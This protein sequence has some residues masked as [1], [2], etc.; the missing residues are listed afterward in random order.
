MSR[1]LWLKQLSESEDFFHEMPHGKSWK[2]GNEG[3]K[4]VFR[5]FWGNSGFS[6][7]ISGQKEWN[8]I[9]KWLK[10]AKIRERY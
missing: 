8:I 3:A 5:D 7:G 2:G 1:L 4:A 6:R 10:K 9:E